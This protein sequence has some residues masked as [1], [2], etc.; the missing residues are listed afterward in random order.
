MTRKEFI[1][2]SAILG[3]GLPFFSSFLTSCSQRSLFA[4]EINPSFNGKVLIVGA[5]S[6]GLMAGYLLKRYGIDFQIIEASSVYGGRVKKAANFADFPIDLGAEWIH[7]NPQILSELLDE[8]DA[9]ADIDIIRYN[10]QSLWIWSEGKLKKRGFFTEFYSE[11]KFASTTWYEFFEQYVVPSI[12]DDIIYDAPVATID[13]TGDEVKIQ[14]RGGDNFSG[15]K[16]IVTVP[17]TVLQNEDI[18]FTPSYP[19]EKK[20]ALSQVEMPDGIKVFMEFSERFYPDLLGFNSLGNFLNAPDG[21]RIYYDAAFKKDTSRHILG[22]F[23]VGA[24]A[25]PYAEI[26]TDEELITYILAELDEIFEGKASQTYI[27][28][29]SQNWSQEPFIRGS[30]THY[31]DYSVQQVLAEPID[32]K[33]YFAGEAYPEASSTVHGAGISAFTAVEAILQS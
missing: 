26:A 15:D 31:E 7:T 27:Q 20:E 25:T 19:A 33:V 12:A 23:T 2:N 5:G 24:E 30:Y 13:Y 3:L 11:Y 22:L 1:K 29:V 14:T 17:L 10:P 16:V 21:E 32:G 18:Q 9:A 28:H 8:E 4:G 6:A